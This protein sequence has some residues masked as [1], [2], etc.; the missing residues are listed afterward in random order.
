MEDISRLLYYANVWTF[1]QS[2]REAKKSGWKN[3]TEDIFE[4][5]NEEMADGESSFTV[6]ETDNDTPPLPKAR[7][8]F[9]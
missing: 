8:H 9:Q 2:L 1:Y 7:G 5:M 3:I 6:T 4:L